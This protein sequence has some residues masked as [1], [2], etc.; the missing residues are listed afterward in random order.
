VLVEQLAERREV[1]DDS[2][3]SQRRSITWL[4]R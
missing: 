2:A 4:S 1:L 3:T